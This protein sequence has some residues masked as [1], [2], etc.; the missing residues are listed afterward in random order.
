MAIRSILVPV[1]AAAIVLSGCATPR[2]P[3][4]LKDSIVAAP[5]ANSPPADKTLDCAGRHLDR[6]AG[7][8]PAGA[9]TLEQKQAD[10]RVCGQ[11]YRYP[12]YLK[13]P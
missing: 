9:A 5:A 13:S 3:P 4:S 11:E 7:R 2:P 6:E 8:P 1:L 12:G 10:D